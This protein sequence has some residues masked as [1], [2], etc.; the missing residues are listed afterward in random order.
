MTDL[1]HLLAAESATQL[2]ARLRAA[3]DTINSAFIRLDGLAVE[4]TTTHGAMQQFLRRAGLGD[5]L[6]GP[7][8][9]VV[10]LDWTCVDQCA[11]EGLALFGVLVRVLQLRGRTVIVCGPMATDLAAVVTE[12][13]LQ[14]HSEPAGWIASAPTGVRRSAPITP[15]LL[16]RSPASGP[17]VTPFLVAVETVMLRHSAAPS[18]IDLTT[19]LLMELLQ[20]IGT[21]AA[22]AWA[23]VVAV[24]HSR[25]RPAVLEIGLAD[26]GDG[27]PRSVL[28]G[29]RLRWLVPLC[30]ASVL[31]AFVA[32]GVTSRPADAG[33][34]A[35]RDVVLRF[36]DVVPAGVV[37]IRSGSALIRLDRALA[38][39]FRP[40]QLSYG[41]GTQIRLEIPLTG[42]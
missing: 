6:I 15:A 5:E 16:F 30:D 18:A 17:T 33:G 23:S 13:G 32:N 29:P 27:L 37:L 31:E 41:F 12:S 39:S 25:R 24:V 11:A 2:R 26:S 4:P 42:S 34:G 19:S 40:T 38:R 35:L 14:Q 8:P 21:H 28:S 36:L 1:D 10:A 9:S 3:R 20:N 22:D 7:P